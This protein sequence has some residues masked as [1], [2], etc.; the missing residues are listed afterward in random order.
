MA[1]QPEVSLELES[2]LVSNARAGDSTAFES[3]V[4]PLRRPLYGYIYK[5]AANPQ[6]AEDLLQDTLVRVLESLP[7]F[8]REARFKTWLFG[9]ATHVCL[10][11][12]RARKRFRLEAQVIGE[13]EA[14]ASPE[15]MAYVAAVLSE[16]EFVFEI[17][18]HVAF[19]FACVSRTLEPEDQA[20]LMLR[21][22]LGFTNQESANILEISEPV[23]RHRLS[24][25]RSIMTK[26]YDGL[27][28]LI[29]KT[30]VCYQCQGLRE[31]TPERNRGKDLVQIEVAPGIPVSAGSLLDARLEIVRNADLEHGGSA[32]LHRMFLQGLSAREES[33]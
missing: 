13:R 10:D 18:E 27:C 8:R 20:A 19:C 5:M 24:S 28:Q 16:P 9:I 7:S 26:N 15:T 23:F 11:H 14:Q 1:P 32:P 6:D 31:L 2:Q 22:V 30:G 25:A 17:R 33:R 29:N 4:G 21:E 3:L 12:L